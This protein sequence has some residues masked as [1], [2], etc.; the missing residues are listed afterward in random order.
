[1]SDKA[2]PPR[3]SR[4]KPRYKIQVEAKIRAQLIGSS[5]KFEFVTENI[6][7]SGLLVTH[8]PGLRHAFND[9]T[10]LEVWLRT[11]PEQEVFFFAKYVRVASENSFAIRIIDI[12]PE[13]LEIFQ[14]FI[15]SHMPD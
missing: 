13:N 12:D 3:D 8:P 9:K 14:D 4:V 11:S 1:M 7:E 10:I 2:H 15:G 5:S 6:S